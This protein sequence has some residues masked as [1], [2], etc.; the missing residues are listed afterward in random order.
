MLCILHNTVE[1][2]TVFYTTLLSALVSDAII[3][4]SENYGAVLRLHLRFRKEKLKSFQLLQTILLTGG[5]SFHHTPIPKKKVKNRSSRH[6]INRR[7]C[8]NTSLKSFIKMTHISGASE[9][10]P[11]LSGFHDPRKVSKYFQNKNPITLLH[12]SLLSLPKFV[13][14]LFSSFCTDMCGRWLWA[15]KLAFCGLSIHF[16]I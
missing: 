5:Q 2:N 11:L 8:E 15:L 7:G 14:C 3:A 1:Y 13:R 16:T 4:T 10:K 6:P 12:N 9:V